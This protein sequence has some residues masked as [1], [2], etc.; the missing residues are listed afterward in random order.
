MVILTSAFVGIGDLEENN[1]MNFYNYIDSHDDD[2]EL[3]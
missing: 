3:V 2:Q 1:R